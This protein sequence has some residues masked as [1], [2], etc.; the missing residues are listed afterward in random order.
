MSIEQFLN[1]ELV[2]LNCQAEKELRIEHF[3]GL[4]MFLLNFSADL[5]PETGR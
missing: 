4:K 5:W 2:L 1:F 3:F